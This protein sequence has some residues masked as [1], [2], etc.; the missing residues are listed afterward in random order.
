MS[1]ISLYTK[2]CWA[3]KIKVQT[4]LI[5]EYKLNTSMVGRIMA[6]TK[7]FHILIPRICDNIISHGK[8]NF[9]DVIKDLEMGRS[10]YIFQVGPI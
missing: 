7:G 2:I 9:T 1:S 4:K 5:Y 6:P 3:Q 8:R 10:L